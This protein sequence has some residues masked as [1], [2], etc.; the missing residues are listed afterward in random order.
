MSK[1]KTERKYS[2]RY[3]LK[4]LLPYLFQKRR[5][6]VTTFLVISLV[7]IMS[8]V[9][10]IIF[11]KI[12][13]ENLVKNR[14]QGMVFAGLVYL[15]LYILNGILTYFQI[16][17]LGIIGN[18]AIY[19]L[20]QDTYRKLQEQSMD[21]FDETPTGKVIST[22]TSDLDQLKALLSGDV[23]SA[24]ISLFMILVMLVIM[25]SVSPLL[26]MVSFIT[27]PLIIMSSYFKRNIERP[28][29]KNFRKTNAKLTAAMAEYI[30]GARI[31]L[32]FV[33]RKENIEEFEKINQRFFEAEIRAI[34]ATSILVS[35]LEI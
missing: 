16:W 28:R 3:L 7:T 27:I 9:N 12:I 8:I 35:L 10:P 18:Q 17:W 29:W 32:S 4:R 34:K 22:L 21:Y 30:T 5:L 31:S 1:K 11:S 24:I 25:F 6:M 2:D 26:T 33:R 13:D 20:R 14:P 15:T 19:Q 23:L